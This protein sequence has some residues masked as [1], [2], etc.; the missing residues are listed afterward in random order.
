MHYMGRYWNRKLITVEQI[1]AGRTGIRW[2]LADLSAASGVSERTLKSIETQSGIPNCRTATL[3][4]IQSA[5][6]DAGIEFITSPD[7]RPG[8]LISPRQ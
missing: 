3:K 1:R 8:I 2:T 5:L 7:G 6:G 4:K